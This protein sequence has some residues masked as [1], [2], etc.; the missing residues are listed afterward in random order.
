MVEVRTSKDVR[1][2]MRFMDDEDKENI[3]HFYSTCLERYYSEFADPEMALMSTDMGS[4]SNDMVDV[5]TNYSG[6]NYRRINAAA[7]GIWDYDK[8]GSGNERERFYT[9][10]QDLEEAINNNQKSMGNIK[11]FRGVPLSYFSN[12][13]IS[14]LEELDSLK[15]GFLFDKRFISTSL[16]EEKCYYKMKNDLG[17]NYNVKIEYLLP[18][19]FT[20]G[21]SIGHASYSPG[22]CEYLINSWNL[23]R[24]VDVKREDEG[25]I[26]TAM[27][28]P[29]KVYD[30]AYRYDTG[31]VK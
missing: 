26:V 17:L 28:I 20:D 5:L 10:A 2:I 9:I 14:S 1:K 21:V 11:V 23:A 13:G 6:Y 27:M 4:Y 24:V 25:A 12:Y 15:G 16:V 8:H 31:A 7:M 22:Q 30:K 3:N 18:E 29:K 19:E